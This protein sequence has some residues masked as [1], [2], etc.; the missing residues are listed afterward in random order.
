MNIVRRNLSMTG[1][2][3][4]INAHHHKGA[5]SLY[6]NLKWVIVI[7]IFAVITPRCIIFLL[8]SLCYVSLNRI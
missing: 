4:E 7:V 6:F 5:A 1:K 8:L 2:C 3:G